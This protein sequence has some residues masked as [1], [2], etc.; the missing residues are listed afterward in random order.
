M[1]ELMPEEALTFPGSLLDR[2]GSVVC[3][4]DLEVASLP[5]DGLRP[6]LL[7]P[8]IA[9]ANARRFR[10]DYRDYDG[11][12]II[13]GMGVTL[14]DSIVGL[15]AVAA[16]RE[17][18]PHLRIAIYRPARA[19][20]YVEALYVLA[21]GAV[22]DERQT[23]PWPGDRFPSRHA[24]VDVG[25]HLFWQR[26]AS[27]P[28][29]DFFCDALGIEPADVADSMKANRWIQAVRVPSLP[30]PW[31][32]EPYVLFC[33]ASS[34]PV[35]SIP[36][37]VRHRLVDFLYQRFGV[38]VLGFGHVG[39]DRYVDIGRLSSTTA[40]FLAWIKHARHVMTC[41]S[42]AVHIAAG[43][44]VPTTAFFTS[45]PSRLRTAHYRSC[46]A[47][48][49]QIP[50]IAGIQAS[51]R[52]QDITAVEEAYRSWCEALPSGGRRPSP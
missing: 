4:Y 35:R 39:H 29:I 21:Q 47:I 20:E 40:E 37:A 36:E 34:T 30:E 27:E 9:N 16:I 50:A 28:M 17:R 41:D 2:S 48:D 52:Q 14:G 46:K 5:A 25:N 13:N 15:S 42:S 18:H 43:F 24:L 19:P 38:P 23:L 3:S 8:R 51:A 31:A 26:F 49:F 45:I 10:F 12:H 22:F 33:P 44:D 1:S 7:D 32:H 6:A 11:L